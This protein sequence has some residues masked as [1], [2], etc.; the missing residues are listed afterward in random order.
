MTVD[1]P[2]PSSHS[3][4]WLPRA[5]LSACVRGVMLRDTRGL[6]LQPAQRLNYFPASPLCCLSWWFSGCSLMLPFDQPDA[7]PQALPGRWVFGGPQ[8]GPRLSCNPGPV[9]AMML[10][11]APD[12][13]QHLIG[14][15]PEDWVNRIDD[16][17]L[18]LPPDWL[19]M[20]EAVQQADGDDRRLALIED[21][22]DQRWQ[23]A[24]PRQTGAARRYQDWTQGLA[25][26]AASSAP[27]RSLRQAERRIKQWAGQSMRQ[28]RGLAR[29]ERAFFDV[30]AAGQPDWSEVALDAGYADQSH[31]CRETRRV[32]GFSPA[33]LHRRIYHDEA[34][35]AYRLWA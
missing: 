33:E 32:T 18:V 12:A 15:R 25:L 17:R 22:L 5:S 7:A 3:R 23:A 2:G 30:A 4:L 21:F 16:A 10:L 24:R 11:L 14:L 29:A 9:H 28:L 1:A 13:L 26:R 8:Q 20:C 34:F 31:L 27:G 35:W 6:A 19:A